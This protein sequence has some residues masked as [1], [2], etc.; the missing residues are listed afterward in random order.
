MQINVVVPSNLAPGVVPVEIRAGD[1]VS[2]RTIT[3]AIR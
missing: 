3:L 2:P 1:K